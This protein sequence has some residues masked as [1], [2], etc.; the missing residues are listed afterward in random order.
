ME[1][2]M[3]GTG[4]MIRRA[5]YRLLTTQLIP[6]LASMQRVNMFLSLPID[7]AYDKDRVFSI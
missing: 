6:R 1:S 7:D 3:E 5:S 4:T 2:C